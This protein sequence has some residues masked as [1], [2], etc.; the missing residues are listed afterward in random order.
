[1]HVLALALGKS[2]AEVGELDAAEIAAWRRF[3]ARHPFG[4]VRGDLQAWL[5]ARNCGEML[6]GK[7][8]SANRAAL[9]MSKH[10]RRKSGNGENITGETLAGIAAVLGCPFT[11]ASAS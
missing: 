7:L 3:Y 11:P 4:Q 2:V 8:R 5:V 10:P 6:N 9:G 1:M